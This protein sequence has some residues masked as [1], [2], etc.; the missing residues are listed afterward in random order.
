MAFTSWTALYQSLLDSLADGDPFV[1]KAN[2]GDKLI[3]WRDLDSLMR[4][5]NWAKQQAA[6]E[7]NASNSPRRRTYAGNAGDGLT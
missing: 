6:L 1:G 4:L 3:E 7:T 5:I 2:Y